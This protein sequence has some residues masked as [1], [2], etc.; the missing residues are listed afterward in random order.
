MPW[1]KP[2][3]RWLPDAFFRNGLK[4]V[5]NLAGIAR[6]RV[7]ARLALEEEE[8]PNGE[9]EEVCRN[10][11]KDPSAATN[12]PPKPSRNSSQAAIQPPIP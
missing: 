12:S 6:A 10:E 1:L 9:V 7:G 11:R 2:Y 5:E 3:A 8:K 4:A